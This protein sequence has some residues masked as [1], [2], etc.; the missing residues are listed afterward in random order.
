MATGVFLSHASADKPLARRLARDLR[1]AGLA[2]WLD[3]WVIGVGES[4]EQHIAQG[5]A[6]TRFVVVLLTPAA[7]RSEWVD[8]EWRSRFE[9]EARSRQVHIVP[10]RGEPCEM[11]DFLAQR[12]PVDLSAG[13]YPLGLRHLLALL[14]HHG[15]ELAV[16]T[17]A[18]DAAGALVADP[19][20]LPIVRPLALELGRGLT[21]WVEPDA[22]GH[23]LFLD[24]MVPALRQSLR[25]DW[26][27]AFPGIAVRGDVDGLPPGGACV[28]VDELPLS[29]FELPVDEWLCE[30]PPEALHALGLAARPGRHPL[31]AAGRSWVQDP[32]AE[33]VEAAGY[34]LWSPPALL[35]LHL[36][37]AMRAHL[38]GFVDVD[39]ARRLVDGLDGDE[40]ALAAQVLPARVRWIELAEVMT[41][42]LDEAIALREPARIVA[43][44][45]GL[46]DGL[47]DTT[48]MTE[49][50]RQALLPART[51][52]FRDETGRVPAW[53]LGAEAEAA[54]LAALTQAGAQGEW[55]NLPQADALLAAVVATVPADAGDTPPPIVVGSPRIR[56]FLRQLVRLERPRHHVFS[57]AELPPGAELRPLGEIAWRPA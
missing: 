17:D 34:R 42:L 18:V 1:A 35:T 3:Q 50:V 53:V 15:A 11:P 51:G 48:A 31:V 32:P 19:E 25:D 49:R 36:H 8:R 14:A 44:L 24:R 56:P 16:A 43:A 54:L 22:D 30:A 4:F 33:G 37:E 7:V 20:R 40:A 2:V 10:V 29:P 55:M 27:F 39:L 45:A 6:D 52:H 9:D 12:R 57:R 47:R 26:G 46:P 38:P 13:S 21:P 23:S 5:L 41:R 28:L